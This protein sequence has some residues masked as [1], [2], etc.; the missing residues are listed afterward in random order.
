MKRTLS[1][2]GRHSLLTFGASLTAGLMLALAVGAV[3]STT[4]SPAAQ[5]PMTHKV[6]P[7]AAAMSIFARAARATDRLPSQTGG[8]FAQFSQA[9]VTA[10]LNPGV[11]E[12]AS[13]R[14]AIAGAGA[15]NASLF[16]VLTDKGSLCMVWSPDVYG[17]GCTEGFEDAAQV[18]FVRGLHNGEMHLWGIR[19]DDVDNI[20]AVVNGQSQ[21]VTLG[22]N[23]FFYEGAVPAKPAQS[24]AQRRLASAGERWRTC[25]VELGRLNWEGAERRTGAQ[26]PLLRSSA[27]RRSCADVPGVAQ[28]S[29]RSQRGCRARGGI[30]TS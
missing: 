1:Y 24:D 9:P 29:S 18:V 11:A 15:A 4:H 17:G 23:A 30:L 20:T 8:V 5:S 2:F 3:A 26:S 27:T 12:H 22:E 6:L 21:P 19:R 25:N 14:R 28:S 10:G 16:L 7:A 13:A